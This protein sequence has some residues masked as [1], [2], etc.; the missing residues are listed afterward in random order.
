MHS[1]DESISPAM[2]ALLA[3]ADTIITITR[4]AREQNEQDWDERMS[5]NVGAEWAHNTDATQL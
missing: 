4:D 2:T 5:S 1:R 3:G